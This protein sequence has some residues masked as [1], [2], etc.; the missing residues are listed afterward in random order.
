MAEVIKMQQPEKKRD[1]LFETIADVC[2]IDISQLTKSARGQL[3]KACSELRDLSPSEDEIRKRAG[4]YREKY[5]EDIPLTPMA[6]VKHWP[7]L[8]PPKESRW[9]LAC[10]LAKEKGLESFKGAPYETADQFMNRVGV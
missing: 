1:I 9:S 7:Q 8:N 4:L 10:R 2:D 3:N 6:L 5:G